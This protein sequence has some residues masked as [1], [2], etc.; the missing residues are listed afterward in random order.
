VRVQTNR[1][2]VVLASDAA[3]FYENMRQQNPF[4]LVYNVGD[5]IEGWRTIASLAEDQT[6]I[7][8]G[9]DPAVAEL[10]QRVPS[11]STEAYSLHEA[12]NAAAWKAFI[13]TA[14]SLSH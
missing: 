8:P 7:I 1:G 5:M 14:S 13:A 2:P 11:I 6:S 10:F 12:P 3:H 4:P 9:H